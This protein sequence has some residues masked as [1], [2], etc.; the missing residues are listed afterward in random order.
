M[1]QK[2]P[3]IFL[4]MSMLLVYCAADIGHYFWIKD[5]IMYHDPVPLMFSGAF[6]ILSALSVLRFFY[7]RERF[8]KS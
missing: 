6:L 2:L 8:G 4:L 7:W 5:D 3:Y 1:K